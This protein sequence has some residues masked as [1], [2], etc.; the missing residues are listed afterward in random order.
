MFNLLYQDM[1]QQLSELNCGITIGTTK[2]NACCYADDVLLSSVS[3]T[4]LHTLIN[5]ANTY[6]T[7]HD[8]TF[9]S[10]KSTCVT[11]GRS[12]F[13]KRQWYIDGQLLSE[14]DSIV[15][16]GVTLANDK[17]SHAHERIK[18]TRRALYALQGAG[19]CEGGV[20]PEVITHVFNTAIRPVLM[21]GLQCVYQCKSA[22]E[23]AE[24][25][26]AKRLK[27]SLGL[28]S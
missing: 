24:K 25:L 14:T 8:L 11:F 13:R 16:L 23:D 18:S 26:Q 2:Y 5:T 10:T 4:G 6:I 22:I 15:Y 20:K 7:R 21:Y 1:M 3:V 12:P 27:S 17:K 19:V 28:R 9:N